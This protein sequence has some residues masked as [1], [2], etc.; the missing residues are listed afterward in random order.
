M[1]LFAGYLRL[2][3][4]WRWS[5]LL[6]LLLAGIVAQPLLVGRVSIADC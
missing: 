6:A 4:R 3:A 1:S 5:L 2:L